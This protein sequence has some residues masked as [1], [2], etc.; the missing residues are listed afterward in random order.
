MTH[1]AEVLARI[2]PIINCLM[3]LTALEFDV[4]G[5]EARSRLNIMLDRLA[6]F[7]YSD[8]NKE[9]AALYARLMDLA[10]Y[11]SVY[12]VE[13][14][15]ILKDIINAWRPIIKRVDESPDA[16]VRPAAIFRIAR[17]ALVPSGNNV[18]DGALELW[19]VIHDVME[20]RA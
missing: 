6:T 2:D 17:S 20:C 1:Q 14:K 8:I 9:N 11:I 18:E 7:D 19:H 13:P 3:G 12:N 16:R 4:C 10:D 15:P 5:P